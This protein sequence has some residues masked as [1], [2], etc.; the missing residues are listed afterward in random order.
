MKSGRMKMLCC[1]GMK[2]KYKK[3]N[4]NLKHLIVGFES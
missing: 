2:K 4:M 3:K 1:E